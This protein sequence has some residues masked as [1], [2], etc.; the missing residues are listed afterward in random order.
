MDFT[1]AKS[2]TINNFQLKDITL[3]PHQCLEPCEAV[4]L[5]L[6]TVRDRLG[7]QIN[8]NRLQGAH[9]DPELRKGSA[10]S[11][12]MLDL[13]IWGPAF[14]LPSIDPECVAA[15]AYLQAA[16]SSS[17]DWRLIPSNDPSLAPASASSITTLPKPQRNSYLTNSYRPPPSSEPRRH[18]DK[19]LHTHCPLPLLPFPRSRPRP[20]P[21]R[22]PKIPSRRPRLHSLPI[23][24]RRSSPRPLPLRLLRQ[25]GRHNTSY[26]LE[27]SPFPTHMDGSDADPRCGAEENRAPWTGR[28]GSRF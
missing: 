18:L 26:I 13:H 3:F 23:R 19:R 21:P 25:L 5:T 4:S 27:N 20:T 6:R 2:C 12:H 15:V 9:C 16:A 7:I 17:S 10:I 8:P 28:V 22:R 1:S 24:P 11:K 14:G